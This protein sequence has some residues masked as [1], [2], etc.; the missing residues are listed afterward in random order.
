MSEAEQ[1]PPPSSLPPPARHR[2]IPLIPDWLTTFTGVLAVA[3]LFLVGTAIWQHFDTAE[4]VRAA[5]RLAE[6]NEKAAKDRRQT[7][8]AE[9]ISKTDAKL[10]QHRFDRITNDIQSNNGTY[11]LPKYP[12]KNDADVE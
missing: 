3:T 9:F 12:N 8:S 5:N 2:I 4:A 7:T 6:A 10:D 11:H 1:A